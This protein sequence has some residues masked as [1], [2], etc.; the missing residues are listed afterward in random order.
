[1]KLLCGE[2]RESR[3][4]GTQ[5]ETGLRAEDRSCACASAIGA[6]LAFLKH[7]PEQI[8]ILSHAEILSWRTH[9]RNRISCC[10]EFVMRRACCLERFR[11]EVVVRT[12]VAK[13]FW[14]EGV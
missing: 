7:E 6:G 3:P 2:Q 14:L 4:G 10:Y 13:Y 1:M 11:I 9:S 5:I 8:V 12:Q